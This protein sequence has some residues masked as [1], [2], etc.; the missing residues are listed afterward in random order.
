[1]KGGPSVAFQLLQ[2]DLVMSQVHITNLFI[3]DDKHT[4][5][6]MVGQSDI[7]SFPSLHED[8]LEEMSWHGNSTL[9]D[10]LQI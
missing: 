9:T 8:D 3:G 10:G 7:L 5:C 2:A 6:G 1:M 4:H